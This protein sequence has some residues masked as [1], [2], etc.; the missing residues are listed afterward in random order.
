MLKGGR[1]NKW[2]KIGCSP[3]G[4]D[5]EDKKMEKQANG[6]KRNEEFQQRLKTCNRLTCAAV[7]K[8]SSNTNDK[9]TKPHEPVYCVPFFSFREYQRNR[10]AFLP[11]NPKEWKNK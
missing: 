8:P 1:A 11:F 2:K 9:I 5:S 10:S 3:D 4:R 6:N 7:D